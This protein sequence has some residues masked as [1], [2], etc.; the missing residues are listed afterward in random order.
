M[1]GPIFAKQ[2][3]IDLYGEINE[4]NVWNGA[5]AL[6]YYLTLSIFP[7]FIVIFTV[8][9]YLPIQDIDQAMMDLLRQALPAETAQLLEGTVAEITQE[10]RG[11]LLSFGILFTLWTV[12]T[13]M[14]AIMQ[15]LNIT[16]DVEEERSFVVARIVA[17]LLSVAFVGL[18]LGAFALVVL[19]GVLESWVMG[20]FGDNGAVVV[21]FRVFRWAVIVLALLLGFALIYKFAPNVD[22]RFRFIS[23]GS[24]LG[25]LLLIV[26][27]LAFTLYI[28]NFGDYDA[29]YGSLGAVIILM[30][31]LYIV[32]LVLLIGS[33]IN[34]LVEHY[35]PE[36]K[37]KGEKTES[38][39]SGFRL[40]GQ[41]GAALRAP[42][43]SGTREP[44]RG[45]V[46]R[47]GA[48]SLIPLA[49]LLVLRAFDHRRR[50][51]RT[52]RGSPAA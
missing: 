50:G 44:V 21:A 36:G 15:Q 38:G 16:Y 5:A 40:H 46:E 8:I 14:Y 25:V 43:E 33:E 49:A 6:A 9:P 4:D 45:G 13:G 39:S 35:A 20:L 47:P 31:W 19:G 1:F 11:G 41:E 32:G 29:T 42:A 48:G 52:G 27:S 10:Q 37:V 7:A 12:S 2:F 3:W 26:A 23:P 51:G 28:Q 34:S 18:V 24:V 30:L 22:Q 17:I